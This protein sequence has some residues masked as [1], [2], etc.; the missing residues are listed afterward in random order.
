[1]L[2]THLT[3]LAITVVIIIFTDFNGLLWLLGKKKTLP[4]KL[5]TVL[6]WLVSFGLV[7][8]ILSGGYM[9]YEYGSEILLR[10][11]VFS[12]KMFFV[13]LLVIN[14]FL[15]GKHMHVAFERSFNDLTKKAKISLLVSG[16]VSTGC[17]I[18]A[19]ILG[20]MLF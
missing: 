15:I 14:A 16:A 2:T 3:I 18:A 4:K 6:H 19:F 10:N 9:A 5:F 8:M 12:T 1:M 20:K 13:L 7:G 17:W 11:Y